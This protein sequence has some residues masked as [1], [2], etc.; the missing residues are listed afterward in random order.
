MT[1]ARVRRLPSAG[2][3]F[4]TR[5]MIGMKNVS[6]LPEHVM[7]VERESASTATWILTYADELVTARV[8]HTIAH[9]GLNGLVAPIIGIQLDQRYR[10][11]ALVGV[12]AVD[13]ALDV[14][15]DFCE[16]C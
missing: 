15:G 11:V 3:V 1:I 7:L 12:L 14:S 6:D 10:P 5:S 9:E 16:A 8:Q 13:R 2:R 4:K